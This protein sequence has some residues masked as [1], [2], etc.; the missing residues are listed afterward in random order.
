MLSEHL[1]CDNRHFYAAMSVT[2]LP[3]ALVVP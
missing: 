3:S 2:L 1:D